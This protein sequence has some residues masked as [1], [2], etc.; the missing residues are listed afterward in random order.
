MSWPSTLADPTALGDPI[1]PR[2]HDAETCEHGHTVQFYENEDSLYDVVA[3]FLIEGLGRDEPAIVIATDTH[4]REFTRRLALRGTDVE[5]ECRGGRLTLLDAPDTLSKFMV[6][7]TPDWELFRGQVGAVVSQSSLRCGGGRV[8]AYGEMVDLLWRGGNPQAALRLEELWNRLARTQS[9]SLLCGYSLQN[10]GHQADSEPFTQICSVHSRVVPTERYM[11]HREPETRLRE[12]SILQQ[13]AHALESEIERRKDLEGA[14]RD[15]LLARQQ[16]EQ[17]LR[18]SKQELTDFVENAVEGLHCVGPDG[19]ILWAN[20]AELALFGYLRE[21]YV[22]HHVAKFHVDRDVI[23]DILGRLRNNEV[24]RDYEARVRCRDGSI[25]YV[26][27]HSN[28]LFRDGEFVHTR[29]FTRDITDR[30]RLEEELRRQNE[31]LSRAV[32]FSE[33]FVGILGH[34]LRNP[35]SAISTAAQVLARRADSDRVTMPAKR[36]LSS[37]YRMSRMIDQLLDF[38]RI[39]LGNGLPLERK[40]VDLADV[41]HLVID[42]FE[43]QDLRGSLKVDKVGDSVGDWDGD[44]L[45][46][47][48][49][50]LLGNALTHG[51]SCGAIRVG[52][53]GTGPEVI[54]E[55]HNQGAIQPEALAGI[56]QPFSGGAARKHERSSG[57]GL[58]LFISQQIVL[59]HGG[60]ID[61][62]SSEGDGTRIIVR[63]PRKGSVDEARP[64][65]GEF[66]A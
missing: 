40:R 65:R 47:L 41:C 2:R 5:E 60:T 38:T 15:A 33:L 58:G 57:F 28:A 55:V 9:F 62:A 7:G 48:A 29:C 35:L 63:L 32:R 49:S 53:D 26:L 12:V 31:E 6:N 46:Q 19:I 27:I 18:A 21:E 25:K 61:V 8:R 42:E 37:A 52:I 66:P 50:N 10:F 59:A 1:A 13:R 20:A 3:E 54:L 44:R 45:A 4:R 23:D 17:A 24:L 43:S 16:T 22:G 34:D 11:A 64:R 30:K 56:F 51:A 39:R 36:I 14:L